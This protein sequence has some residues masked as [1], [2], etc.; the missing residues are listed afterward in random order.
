MDYLAALKQRI[1]LATQKDVI[2]GMFVENSLTLVSQLK[3]QQ[4]ADDLRTRILGGKKLVSFFRYPVADLLKVME[5][6][7]EGAPDPAALLEEFGANSVRIFFDSPVGR[8]MLML[9]SSNPHKLLFSAPA[10]FRASS[11]FGERVY[12]KE[13]DTS[14]VMETNGDLLGPSWTVGV[15]KYALGAACNIKVNV[16][17]LNPD[18]AGLSYHARVTW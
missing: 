1:T 4:F 13:T 8:T 10:G 9:A 3:S 7:V 5:A 2:H 11:S 14:G 15:F 17:V 12:K 16:E 6:T 18:A